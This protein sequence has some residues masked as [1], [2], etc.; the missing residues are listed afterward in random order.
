MTT[1]DGPQRLLDTLRYIADTEDKLNA[2]SGTGVVFRTGVV[3][4]SLPQLTLS[5]DGESSMGGPMIFDASQ[6]DLLVPEDLF[7]TTGD[8]VVLAPLSKR[9]WVVLFK[10][11]TSADQ[12]YRARYGINNDRNGG[13]FAGLEI[14]EDPNTGHVTVTLVGTNTNVNGDT[15]LSNGGGFGGGE[16]GPPGPIGPEG[17]PG[18]PGPA[19]PQSTVPGPT[20]PPGPNGPPGL[21]GPT[22]PQGPAGPQGLT[23]ATGSIGNTGPQGPQGAVGPTGPQ[24]NVGPQGA[25]GDKGDTGAQGT[26]GIQGPQGVT[27]PTGSQGP[28][29]DT[30]LTGPQGSQGTTGATGPQGPAATVNAGTTATSAPGT[31]ANV[32][33]AG[34]TSAAVFNFTIPRGDVGAQGATGA[35]GLQ[36]PVGPQGPTGSTGSQGIPGPTGPQGTQG[37]TGP[38]GP[39]GPP[40]G[41]TM[42]EES[43]PVNGTTVVNTSQ[44]PDS[45]IYVSRNGIVQSSQDGHFTQAGGVFTFSTPLDG[46]ERVEISYVVGSIGGV[47]PPGPPG[48]NAAVHEEFLPANAATTV[49][50][51]QTPTVLLTV[52]RGGIIQ[53]QTD[54]NYSL[55]GRTI[56]FTDAF[57]GTERV[58]VCYVSNTYV[59]PSFV[60]TPAIDTVLRAYIS[61]LMTPIDPGGPP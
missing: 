15:V 39:I 20:G 9:K 41:T 53:S 30:G 10:T 35:Q 11:R 50:L 33:N 61:R 26:Q 28:K 38:T 54:G 42:R 36:G 13:E 21:T 59:P 56:T 12:V 52:S 44:V 5:M 51:G 37:P 43:K 17:P 48:P 49:A 19:G 25:K 58:V 7:L 40:G 34:S 27:G 31:N 4:S 57:D 24:G 18:P 47:G 23:G 32:V 29:G 16:V 14:T 60:V 1:L 6:G 46:T 45:L 8:T 3:L 22:G 55:S 2:L